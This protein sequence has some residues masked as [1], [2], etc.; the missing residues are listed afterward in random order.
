MKVKDLILELQKQNPESEIEFV[1]FIEY[2]FQECME[3]VTE[4]CLLREDSGSVQLIISGES[5]K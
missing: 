2:G 1:G 3:V 5:L 4:D